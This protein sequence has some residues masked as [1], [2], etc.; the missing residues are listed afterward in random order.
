M[1]EM[2]DKIENNIINQNDNDVNE[3]NNYEELFGE[4]IEE[5]LEEENKKLL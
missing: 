1:N 3:K 2:N 4:N 5:Y